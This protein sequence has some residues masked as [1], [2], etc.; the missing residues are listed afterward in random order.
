MSTDTL[1]SA[2][3][4]A[5]SAILGGQAGEAADAEGTYLLECFAPDGTL[6][7]R[8]EV[9][10]VV[11][12][13]GKNFVLDNALAGSAY[14]AAWLLSLFT[15]GTPAATATY[16]SPVVTEVTS[17]VLAS[18]PAITWTAAASGSKTSNTVACS[19]VGSATI[20]GVMVVKGSSTIGDTAQAGG[21]LLSE[22]TL[23]SS[24]AVLSGDTL[25]VTY[26]LSI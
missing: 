26:S 14:T 16:A 20:T 9:H 17:G 8:E 22:G 6:R 23:G 18:R 10:N 5:A 2:A 11:T 3:A 21:V 13:Q 24:R 7:W 25:N 19:M 12:T 1:H 15:A 4:L